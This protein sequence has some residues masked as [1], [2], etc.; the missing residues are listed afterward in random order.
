GGGGG[1]GADGGLGRI[2]VTGFSSNTFSGALGRAGTLFVQQAG[3]GGVLTLDSTTITIAPGQ[4]RTYG[5]LA[6]ANGPS[7][8]FNQ[9]T[10]ALTTDALTIPN[11]LTLVQDGVVKGANRADAT[12]GSFT[13]E[14]G[15]LV[16]HSRGSLAGVNL[17]IAGTLTV[18]S[19]G[20]I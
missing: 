20:S 16:T 13:V 14:S 18:Q 19:G 4:T 10:L 1:R 11:L 8:I 2:A 17:N 3:T 9:G 12:I 6:T 7:T 15:G 5:S